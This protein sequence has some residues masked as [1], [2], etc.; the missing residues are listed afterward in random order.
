MDQFLSRLKEDNWPKYSISR[1]VV[2][3]FSKVHNQS[4]LLWPSHDDDGD[5][6]V[7]GHFWYLVDR[8]KMKNVKWVSHNVVISSVIAPKSIEREI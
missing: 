1:V 3:I 7:I 2:Q 6:C 4:G 5:H 8:K